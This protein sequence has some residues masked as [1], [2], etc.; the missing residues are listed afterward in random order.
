[1]LNGFLVIQGLMNW[2]SHLLRILG[3]HGSLLIIRW[4]IVVRIPRPIYI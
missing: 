4:L 2:L 3:V 1:M